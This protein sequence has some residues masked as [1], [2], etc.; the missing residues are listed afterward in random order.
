MPFPIILNTAS[1]P[2]DYLPQARKN[3]DEGRKEKPPIY[4]QYMDKDTDKALISEYYNMGGFQEFPNQDE[5][6]YKNFSSPDFGDKFRLQTTTFQ[7]AYAVTEKDRYYNKNSAQRLAWCNKEMGRAA[8]R[9]QERIAAT[10]LNLGWSTTRPTIDRKPYFSRTHQGLNG[11]IY[12]NTPETQ[13]DLNQASLEA[14]IAGASL[15]RDESGNYLDIKYRYLVYHPSQAPNAHRVLNSKMIFNGT[16][17]N[18]FPNAPATGIE[19]TYINNYGLI[20]I[21]NP[22]LVDEDAWFLLAEK[23]ANGLVYKESRPLHEKMYSDND[24]DNWVYSLAFDA[25]AAAYE[26]RGA[27]GSQGG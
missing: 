12:V 11:G 26:G 4:P 8:S 27:Y 6:D 10:P 21:E 22:Y 7:L 2:A 15:L 18:N 17:Q 19:N 20:P 14:A 5:G 1:R 23:G 24:T 3:I 25:E 13:V 16:G 9:T